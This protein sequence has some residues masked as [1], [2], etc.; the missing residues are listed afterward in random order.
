MLNYRFEQICLDV[1]PEVLRR[2][3]LEKSA[4]NVA[5]AFDEDADA[6]ETM[7]GGGNGR[8]GV[9]DSGDVE[10]G[11]EQLVPVA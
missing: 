9:F 5:G 2:E 1:R 3:F 6:A 7:D 11:D 4:V 10:L 8:I